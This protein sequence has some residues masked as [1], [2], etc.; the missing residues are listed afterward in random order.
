MQRD[1]PDV[2]SLVGALAT[3]IPAS[4]RQVAVT[5]IP[6]FSSIINQ[7]FL[8]GK[9]PQWFL[10][11]PPALQSYLISRFGIPTSA[12]IASAVP[13]SLPPASTTLQTWPDNVSSAPTLYRSRTLIPT[14][15]ASPVQTVQTVPT[16]SS[17]TTRPPQSLVSSHTTSQHP[18][19][20]AELTTANNSGLTRN[21]KIGIGIGVPLGLV[22]LA[23]LLLFCCLLR[24]RWRKNANGSVPPSSPG[25]I[26][27]FA[28]QQNDCEDG[29]AH[30]HLTPRANREHGGADRWVWGSDQ[31]KPDLGR[32][33]DIPPPTMAPALCHTHSSNRARGRRTSYTSLNTVVECSEPGDARNS[34][35]SIQPAS[36]QPPF[37]TPASSVSTIKRK[38]VSSPPLIIPTTGQNYATETVSPENSNFVY[39]WPSSGMSSNPVVSPILPPASRDPPWGDES[40]MEDYGPEYDDRAVYG[41]GG[42]FD[43]STSSSLHHLVEKDSTSEWPLQNNRA[44]NHH[45]SRSLMWDRVYHP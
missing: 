1:I 24:R 19:A 11:L 42:Q 38:P 29:D 23:A 36:S 4:I 41:G 26:P 25:F 27:R 7:E 28:F 14:E 6:M 31:A 44:R 20:Q 39:S 32:R 45:R 21:A 43:G 37:F 40:Y 34:I 17:A 3:A 15:V 9:R 22:A 8:D 30:R 2:I 16:A 12:T 13:T 33:E 35:H 10:D 5:N 18:T